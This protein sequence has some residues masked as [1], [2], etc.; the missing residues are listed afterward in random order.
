[1]A[2]KPNYRFERMERERKKAA[3]KAEKAERKGKEDSLT[4]ADGLGGDA[5]PDVALDEADT[6]VSSAETATGPGIDTAVEP[7]AEPV[8]EPA[9]PKLSLWPK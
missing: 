4:P 3:K 8:A 1:M 5:A 7:V 9:R 2:R 6:T